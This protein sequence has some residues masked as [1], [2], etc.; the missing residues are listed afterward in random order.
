MRNWSL[1]KKWEELIA[2]Q[3]DSKNTVREFPSFCKENNKKKSFIF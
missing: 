2:L 3:V 1:K